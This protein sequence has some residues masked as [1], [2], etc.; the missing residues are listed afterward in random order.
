MNFF[1]TCTHLI[2]LGA[3]LGAWN[4]WLI[5]LFWFNVRHPEGICRQQKH[6]QQ[7]SDVYEPVRFV[8]G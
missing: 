4:C 5:D 3:G 1:L 7:P 2:L 8:E 6:K